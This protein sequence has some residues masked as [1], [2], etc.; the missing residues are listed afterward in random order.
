MM[1]DGVADHGRDISGNHSGVKGRDNS[2]ISMRLSVADVNFSQNARSKLP[3]HR[4][5]ANRFEKRICPSGH[6]H[7]Q[8]ESGPAVYKPISG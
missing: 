3:T 4:Q 1:N 2:V 8:P 6:R 5:F 7:L